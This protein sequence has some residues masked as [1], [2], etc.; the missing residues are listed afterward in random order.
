MSR[1]EVVIYST[2]DYFIQELLKV[3]GG[4]MRIIEK[5]DLYYSVKNQEKNDLYKLLNQSND[6]GVFYPNENY[7]YETLL[8]INATLDKTVFNKECFELLCVYSTG[9]I[10]LKDSYNRTALSI[11]CMKNNKEAILTLLAFGA[12]LNLVDSYGKKAFEYITDYSVIGDIEE[13]FIYP[14]SKKGAEV[15]GV[16][17]WLDDFKSF[18]FGSEQEEVNFLI[19]LLVNKTKDVKSFLKKCEELNVKVYTI[20][21]DSNKVKDIKIVKNDKDFLLSEINPNFTPQKFVQRLDINYFETLSTLLTQNYK[22]D[23]IIRNIIIEQE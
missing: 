21:D 9:Y 16:P 8:H 13:Y 7:G 22:N 2:P 5:D 20:V 23:G 18:I 14:F 12:N 15:K 10:D 6:T 19:N 1:F 4:A 17:Y 3:P 11:A